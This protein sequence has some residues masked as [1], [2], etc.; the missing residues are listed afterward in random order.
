VCIRQSWNNSDLG[1]SATEKTDGVGPSI[2][3]TLEVILYKTV[4]LPADLCGCERWAF[5][6]AEEYG[7]QK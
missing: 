1:I 4:M 5:A 3:W 6:V 2:F 7:V